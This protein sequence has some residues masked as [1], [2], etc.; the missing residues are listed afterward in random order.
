LGRRGFDGGGD[1][2]CVVAKEGI[3]QLVN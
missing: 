1:W 3:K 2:E